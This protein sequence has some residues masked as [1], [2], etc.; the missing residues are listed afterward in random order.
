VRVIVDT[1]IIVSGLISSSG[2][3]AKIVNALLQGLLIPVLS[4]DTLAELEAV[5]TRPRLQ[6]LFSRAGVEAEEFLGEFRRLAE[7]IEPEPVDISV[8]D[9]KDRI[10]L[11]LAAT[12]PPVDFLITGDRDFERKQYAGVPVISAALFVKAVLS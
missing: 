7:I 8:R 10:F 5:L 6:T 9:E 1:N 3:P 11:E 4:S 12:R 2:P